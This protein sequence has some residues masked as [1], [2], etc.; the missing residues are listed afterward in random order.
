MAN[1]IYI[2]SNHI[3]LDKVIGESRIGVTVKDKLQKVA[4]WLQRSKLAHCG[5]VLN[6]NEVSSQ[7]LLP[8]NKDELLHGILLHFFPIL[9]IHTLYNL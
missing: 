3:G 6:F 5:S 8:M 9:W 7:S 2:F 4:G 1:C